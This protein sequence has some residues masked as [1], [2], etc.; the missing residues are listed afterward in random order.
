MKDKK[1]TASSL[2]NQQKRWTKGPEDPQLIRH[3]HSQSNSWTLEIEIRKNMSRTYADTPHNFWKKEK[4][5]KRS[6]WPTQGLNHSQSPESCLAMSDVST[7]P[8]M[9]IF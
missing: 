5:K 8:Q 1:S 9:P 3:A 6:A 7:Q 2:M 4:K